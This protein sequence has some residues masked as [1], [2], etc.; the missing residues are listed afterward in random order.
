MK[1][2]EEKKKKKKERTKKRVW[3]LER[4]RDGGW[5]VVQAREAYNKWENLERVSI[6][7]TQ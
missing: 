5:E 3:D 6:R 2:R 1:Q 4:E 7:H